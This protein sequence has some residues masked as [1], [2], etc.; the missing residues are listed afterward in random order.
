MINFVICEDEKD[1]RK[2]EVAEITKFMMN[3][4]IDYKIHEYS[5]YDKNFYEYAKKEEFKVYLLDIVTGKTSGIDAA[6]RI[7][8]EYD[9]WTSVIM[10]VTSHPEY[11]YEVLSSRLYLLDFVNKLND[12]ENKIQEDLNI[13]MKHYD[14]RHKQLKFIYNRSY[15]N[16]ELREI[17]YIEKEPD[18]KRCIIST[19]YGKEIIPGTLDSIYNKLDNRFIKT[20]KSLIVNLDELR[21]FDIK[22]SKITFKNG[23]TSYLVSRNRKKELIKNVNSSR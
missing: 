13:A 2:I 5:T 4:D 16:I 9:D 1:I 22:S 6:R 21:S 11:K 19:K 15:Y 14:K 17:I 10:M 3:Y 7:R 20:H 8:E 23:E 18:S 12:M